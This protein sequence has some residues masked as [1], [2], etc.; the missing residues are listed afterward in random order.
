MN[1]RV[2]DKKKKEEKKGGDVLNLSLL[3]AK[4]VSS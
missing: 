4:V 1:I 3:Q 2:T